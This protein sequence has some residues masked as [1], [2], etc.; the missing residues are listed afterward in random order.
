MLLCGLVACACAWWGAKTV[1]AQGLVKEQKR[2]EQSRKEREQQTAFPTQIPQ[3]HTHH[4]QQQQNN[5][6]VFT[7][8][9]G[10]ESTVAVA[11]L[12]VW[13]IIIEVL[14]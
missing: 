5:T 6:T 11:L 4:H 2:R 13:P 10:K 3:P 7:S 14:C 1:V 12:C 8:S 9:V